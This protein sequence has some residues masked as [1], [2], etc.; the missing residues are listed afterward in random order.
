M[1]TI[2]LLANANSVIKK[3]AAWQMICGRMNKFL[4]KKCKKF[5]PLPDVLSCFL[6]SPALGSK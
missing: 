6:P 3:G 1:D 2:G 5:K 4:L